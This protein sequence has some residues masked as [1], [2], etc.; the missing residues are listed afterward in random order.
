VCMSIAT[1]RIRA[2]RSGPS[3]SKKAFTQA[4]SR[5]RPTQRTRFRVGSMMTV[6]YRE[7]ERVG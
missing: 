4:R 7:R 5:P 6:A 1:A 2:Q 3:A